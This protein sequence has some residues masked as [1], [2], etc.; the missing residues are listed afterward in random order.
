MKDP[1]YQISYI[2][3]YPGSRMLGPRVPVNR[4]LTGIKPQVLE[5]E[6]QWIA[7]SC[8]SSDLGYT[9]SLYI[10]FV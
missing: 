9:P 1:I 3:L 2:L 7:F 10:F 5:R 6:G 4:V 8:V